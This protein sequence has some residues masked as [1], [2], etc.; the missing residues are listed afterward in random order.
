[1]G[2]HRE[3]AR[4]RGVLASEFYAVQSTSVVGK[5]RLREILPEHL[6][7]Q[8][9]M[10]MSGN[11]AFAGPLSDDSGKSCSGAGLIVY[12]AAG[13]QAAREL[14]AADPMTPCPHTRIR[15]PDIRSSPP[16]SQ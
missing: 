13:P 3:S 5:D 11:L 2:I 10:D 8:A 1:M 9:R 4:P 16:A 7:Y 6:A 15:L 14:A 12:R